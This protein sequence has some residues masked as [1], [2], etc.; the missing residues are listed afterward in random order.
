MLRHGFIH[1]LQTLHYFHICCL[2]TRLLTFAL[3][4]LSPI[5]HTHLIWTH[6]WL[7]PLEANLIYQDQINNPAGVGEQAGF[8]EGNLAERLHWIRERNPRVINQ[9]KDAFR[10][11]HNDRLFCQI[12]KTDFQNEYGVPY[13]IIEGH[14]VIPISQMQPGAVTMA[15]D[16]V[17][18]CPNCHRMVHRY[19]PW[20]TREQFDDF[21][22]ENFR[23]YQH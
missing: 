4:G 8:P 20:I 15:R 16:I 19:R 12:C 10:Q 2:A 7:P 9:A 5:E 11:A 6:F 21:S 1:R 14:H 3:M 13:T 18:L 22:V 23:N 17:M